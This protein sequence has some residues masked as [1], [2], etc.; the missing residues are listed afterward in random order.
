MNINLTVPYKILD[1]TWCLLVCI[2]VFLT[3]VSTFIVL[4]VTANIATMPT[5]TPL[6]GAQL[7]TLIDEAS[8]IAIEYILY[9]GVAA[10][11]VWG[12]RDIL[13]SKR[14]QQTSTEQ[15]QT[16]EQLKH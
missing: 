12:L 15:I 16:T 11:T 14:D 1:I 7:F 13:K 5:D 10:F 6:S 9:S 8:E 2:F 3:S 4:L